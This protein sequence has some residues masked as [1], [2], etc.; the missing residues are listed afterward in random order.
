MR[1]PRLKLIAFA[2][3]NLAFTSGMTSAAPATGEADAPARAVWTD[4]GPIL[5]TPSG[6]TLYTYGA[7]GAL[8]GKSACSATPEKDY[9]DQ[10]G[11]LGRAPLIGAAIHKSCAQK[12][13]PYLAEANAQ[14]RGEFSLTDRAEG[15][16]QWTYRGYPLY[17]S[18]RDQKP[19]DR[20]GHSGG[21]FPPPHSD[22]EGFRFATAHVDLPAG[23][24]FMRL[25]EGLALIGANGKPVYTPGDVRF[26]KA[27]NG[28]DSGL[29]QPILAP[30]LA[31]V[32]G[33]WSIVSA[34]AGR[35]QFA[36]KG[37][38]LYAAPES[39][40]EYDIAQLGG[41]KVVLFRKG[42]GTP[43]EVSKQLT[44]L[45]DVYA[46]KAGRTLYTFSCLSPAGDGVNCDDPGDPA[47]YWVALCGDAKECARRWH[48]Y[49]APPNAR[50]VG[51]WSVV[52]VAYPMFTSNPGITYPPEAPRVKAWAYRGVPVY[53]Y[54]E[55]KAPGDIWGD[56]VRWIGGSAF[57]A[58]LVS[59]RSILH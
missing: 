25:E 44:L 4:D 28:C 23:L 41:W 21:G 27:C 22:G 38:P 12:W 3:A 11:G 45:G 18:I 40:A 37:Q 8:R 7:D 24:K 32:S 31:S 48:P 19:G 30:A 5:V 54:Y 51:L 16:K 47:G 10:Q 15:G 59:D 14:S 26:S 33:D 1:Y 56:E 43:R 58:L 42:T 53:T 29:F 6:M 50:P 55:D 17:L 49:V 13:P 46:D 57:Y 35:R 20:L 36:F 34:G 39:Q 9:D 52:D 2:I